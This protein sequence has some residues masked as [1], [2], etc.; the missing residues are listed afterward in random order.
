MLRCQAAGVVRPLTSTVVATD[1]D[2]YLDHS[3]DR[4]KYR[5]SEM[6]QAFRYDVIRTAYEKVN[7]N[8]M[9]IM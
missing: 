7:I 8:A 1:M 4:S 2:G 9:A 5:A 3:L 6:P